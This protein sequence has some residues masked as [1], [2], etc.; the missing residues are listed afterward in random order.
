MYEHLGKTALCTA[1]YKKTKDGVHIECWDKDGI[2]SEKSYGKIE[3]AFAWNK[4]G[5]VEELFFEGSGIEKT[6][7]TLV[8]KKFAG[9]CVG[10]VKLPII[11]L[12]YADFTYNWQDEEERFIAKD[13]KQSC[14]CYII[15]YANNKKHYVPKDCCEFL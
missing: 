4:E 12:L 14:E 9:V 5:M 15:Y 13:I 11:E 10:E 3:K 6:L 7:Y 1:F 2:P 8:S